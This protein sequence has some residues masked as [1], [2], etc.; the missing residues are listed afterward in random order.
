M[1]ANLGSVSGVKESG[2]RLD[3]VGRSVRTHIFEWGEDLGGERTE[4][5]GWKRDG[6]TSSRRKA[7]ERREGGRDTKRSHNPDR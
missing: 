2:I 3:I 1:E 5:M 4:R 6:A 7:R